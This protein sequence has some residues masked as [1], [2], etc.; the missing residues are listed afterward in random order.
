V[1]SV[2]YVIFHESL[3]I[4]FEGLREGVGGGRTEEDDAGES[5]A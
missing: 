4:I 1:R 2:S 3:S 5:I